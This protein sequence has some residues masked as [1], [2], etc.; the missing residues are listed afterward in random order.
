MTVHHH[1][2]TEEPGRHT[3]FR[4]GLFSFDGLSGEV[5]HIVHL[6]RWNLKAVFCQLGH[7]L[8]T[9]PVQGTIARSIGLGTESCMRL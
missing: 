3:T 9:V 4:C 6:I 5:K 2:M 8:N 7:D 1:V